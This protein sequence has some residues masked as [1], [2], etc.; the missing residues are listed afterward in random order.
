MRITEEKWYPTNSFWI[1]L[2]VKIYLTRLFRRRYIAFTLTLVTQISKRE[3][4][5]QIIRKIVTT[6][7]RDPKQYHIR[8]INYDVSTG[9]GIVRCDHKVTN[10]LLSILRNLEVCKGIRL[11]TIRTSGSI[12]S[13]KQK[14]AQAKEKTTFN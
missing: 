11:K 1:K 14:I 5:A 3:L 9:L 10:L 13:L 7:S 6:N 2:D 8:I 4:L 12:K